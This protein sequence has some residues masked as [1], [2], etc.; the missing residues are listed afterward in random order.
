MLAE[1]DE[2]KKREGRGGQTKN[3]LACKFGGLEL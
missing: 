2:G 3:E 1:C